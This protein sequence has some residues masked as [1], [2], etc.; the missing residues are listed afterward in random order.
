MNSISYSGAA[1]N[2]NNNNGVLASNFGIGTGGLRGVGASIIGGNPSNG[3]HP[4]VPQVKLQHLRSPTLE[5]SV[6]SH[7]GYSAINSGNEGNRV[8]LI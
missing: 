5:D 4:L 2:H 6:M 3:G 8:S 1:S 7:G